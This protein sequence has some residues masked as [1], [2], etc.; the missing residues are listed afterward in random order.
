[1][2]LCKESFPGVDS[3]VLTHSRTFNE[4]P[5]LLDLDSSNGCAV[6]DEDIPPSRFY[7]L[8]SGDTITFGASTREYV[9]L[10]EE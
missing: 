9:L 6:N 1:M 2:C 8:K 4:R 7:E 3:C 10:A 5:F